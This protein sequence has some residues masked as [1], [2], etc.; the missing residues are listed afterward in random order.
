MSY[1]QQ[2]FGKSP[3]DLNYQDIVLFFSTQRTESDKIEFKSYHSS[4]HQQTARESKDV[5][6]KIIETICAF[7]NSSGGLLI[8]GA[9]VGEKVAGKKEKV[10]QG[11]LSPVTEN[12][13]KDYFISKVTDLI[14]PMP[15]NIYF[16]TLD[17]NGCY[18]YL[19]EVLQSKYSPHQFHNNYYMRIDAQT[20]IAPHHYI[21]A[22]FKKITYPKLKGF[23]SLEK[24][25]TDQ[26][27]YYFDLIAFIFNLSRLQNEN[28]AF[29]HIVI[30][31][32][33][34]YFSTA[35][36]PLGP[37]INNH[38]SYSVTRNEII[39]IITNNNTIYYNYPLKISEQIQLDRRSLQQNNYE[40]DVLFYFGGERSPLLLS[41]YKLRI[42]PTSSIDPND[43]N[44]LFLISD[45]NRYAFEHADELGLTEE[46]IV[47]K[48][49]G[50]KKPK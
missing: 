37:R 17:D 46:Q 47:N 11:K 25:I 21:E 45:E 7:L 22:L 10:F 42:D 4:R 30:P 24:F 32:S 35:F 16:H 38:L 6:D 49:L 3:L 34:V 31:T 20:R 29:Y 13:E 41:K 1:I 44:S 50:R 40:F 14:T 8:W 5:I 18:I 19:I 39:A 23:I 15:N 12:I 48:T 9:P 26:N 27:F 33:G 28:K 36:N 43:L 2:Y